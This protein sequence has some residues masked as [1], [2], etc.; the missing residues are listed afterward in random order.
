MR[1]RNTS[2]SICLEKVLKKFIIK[3]EK[4]GR[5]II[6]GISGILSLSKD[7]AVKFPMSKTYYAV[8]SYMSCT[9]YIPCKVQTQGNTVFSCYKWGGFSSMVISGSMPLS[10]RQVWV[11]F[12]PDFLQTF[13]MVDLRQLPAMDSTVK[14]AWQEHKLPLLQNSKLFTGLSKRIFLLCCLSCTVQYITRY[15]T[16]IY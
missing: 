10:C 4:T 12:L 7:Q 11:K 8:Y 13:D 5:G 2:C 14:L 1:L 3:C 16:K 6:S 9:K 15:V